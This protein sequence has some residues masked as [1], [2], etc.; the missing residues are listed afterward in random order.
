MEPVPLATPCRGWK[1][2]TI[3]FFLKYPL[4]LNFSTFFHVFFFFFGWV[5]W[6]RA[7]NVEWNSDGKRIKEGKGG[8]HEEWNTTLEL[9]IRSLGYSNIHRQLRGVSGRSTQCNRRWIHIDY[10]CGRY[11]H[12]LRW[13]MKSGFPGTIFRWHSAGGRIVAAVMVWFSICNGTQLREIS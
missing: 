6:L 13:R 1:N 7:R 8:H 2:I 5:H 9:I 12:S 3:T 11:H 10:Y 4:N